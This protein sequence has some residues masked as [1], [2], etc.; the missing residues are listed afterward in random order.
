M[1][2][3][4]KI[5]IWFFIRQRCYILNFFKAIIFCFSILRFIRNIYTHTGPQKSRRHLFLICCPWPSHHTSISR[6]TPSSWNK[7][8]FSRLVLLLLLFFWFLCFVLFSWDQVSLG[9]PGYSGTCFIDHTGLKL[10]HLSAS[11]SFVLGLKPC[12]VPHYA[13]ACFC[14][15]EGSHFGHDQ[16]KLLYLS[17]VH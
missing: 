11:H 12:R 10:S 1:I 15:A 6:V 17:T 8:L 16:F 9:S 13:S 4:I 3:N 2:Y 14:I 5:H 7:C